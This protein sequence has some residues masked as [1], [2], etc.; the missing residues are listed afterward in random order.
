MLVPTS[1]HATPARALDAARSA[2]WEDPLD[3]LAVAID[4]HAGARAQADRPLQA[5]A[6]ALQGLISLHRGDLRGAFALA[7]DAEREAGNDDRAGAELAA[8]M[9]H[10]DFFSGSYAA[11]LGHAERAIALADLTGD[12]TLRVFA[13]RMGCIAFGNLGVPDWPDRLEATLALAVESG[14]R[15][16]EAMSRNDLAHLRMEQGDLAAADVEIERGIALA[17]ALAPANRFA[18]GVLHCTRTEMRTRAGRPEEALAD[19]DV[20]IGHL[21]ASGDPNPYLLGMSVLVKV[22]ALIALDRVDDALAAGEGALARLGERVPQARSMIL[23][24][25]AAALREAGRPEQA[26][27]ALLRCAELEREAMREFTELQLGLQRAHLEIE[28]ARREAESLRDQVDRDPLTGLHNRRYLDRAR[29]GGTLALHGPVSLAV[30]DLDHFKA[31]NDR[32][33]HPVGDRVLM[34][35]A[36][37]L[38]EELRVEDVIARTGGEE[39]MVLMPHTEAADAWACCERL[40]AAFHA[41]PWERIAPGLSLTTSIGVV[42]APDAGDLDGLERD[43]DDRLYAAKRAGRDRAV[44]GP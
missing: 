13:R 37:L 19:A 22:Q 34:R 10:L 43:A 28:A 9:T 1:I 42:S 27:D 12:A 4:V 6:L 23:G 31:V 16:E 5:R 25:V 8:L 38:V 24:T 33:G 41:E 7:A 32:F 18:L 20:A 21:T 40:R 15:W 44:A 14:E 26:Y 35:V 36:A 17:A 39:F 30:I 3:S 2:Y 29:G 11:A